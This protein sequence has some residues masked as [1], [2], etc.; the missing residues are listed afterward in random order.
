MMQNL[1]VALSDSYKMLLLLLETIHT[2]DGGKKLIIERN[3]PTIQ[4]VQ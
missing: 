1:K 4:N 2:E 3:F